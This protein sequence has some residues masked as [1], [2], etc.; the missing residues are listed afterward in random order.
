M[1]INLADND[2]RD[3]YTVADGNSQTVFT[4]SFEIFDDEDLNV[5]IDG[6]LQTLTTNYKISDS[7][8][9]A[10]AGHTSGTTGHVHMTSAV[11]ASGADKIIVLTRDI[12]HKRTTDFPASG[13][14]QIGS[15]NTELDKLIAIAADLNDEIGRSLRLTD[16]DTSVSLVLPDVDSRKGTVLAFDSTTGAVVA[17][18]QTG[19]VNTLASIATD[20]ATLA[21]IEDGTDATD[22]IQDVAAIAS[23]VTTVA[24]IDSNV[25]TVAGIQANVTTVAGIDT[26]VTAVA[27]IDTDVSDV[28]A[29]AGNVTTVAGIDTEVTTVSGDSADIQTLANLS[30]EIGNLGVSSITT[31][32]SALA[33]TAVINDMDALADLTTEID[34]L[35]DITSDITDVAAVDSDVTT[36]AGEISPTNNISTVAGKATE[37]GRLGTTAAVADM[38]ALGASAVVADMDTLA[39]ISAD[40]T[41]LAHL[42]DGTDATNAISD[43]AAISADITAVAAIEQDIQDVQDE[44][45]NIQTLANDLNE[46][47]SEIDTVAASIA[48]VDLVGGSITN[49]NTVATNLTS[50]NN[51]GERYRVSAT[52]PSTS[53][54][55]G[56]LWFDTTNDVMKVYGSGGF[57][58]AGSSVNGTSNRVD[59]VVGTASGDYDGT[60][61]TVFEATYDAGYVDVYLNGIKLQPADFTA[62]NGTDIT[63]ATAAQTSDTVSI[64]GYGTFNLANFSINDAN[65]VSTSGITNGQVLAYNSTTTNFEAA[66]ITEAT[67]NE[68]ENVVED[69]TPQLGGNL[70]VNSN[71]IVS[72]SNGDIELEPNGTGVV[73]VDGT[74]KLDN[75]GTDWTFEIDTNKLV[76]KYGGTAKM[77]LDTSGNLKVTGDVTAFG[78]I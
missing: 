53:L 69:T 7:A 5:Y 14:F 38:A 47:T 43:L 4:M 48:N 31:A 40:I 77:E 44:I 30:T 19:N 57:A 16:Y 42:E 76:I 72:T 58:N 6:T 67:G 39:D 41:T 52:A 46:V 28:A 10:D 32:M 59:Y 3:S 62:T 13:A 65:D 56:D 24:N 68:L 63:L 70:D 75:G 50:V 11:V 1:T 27:A 34:A 12:E 26:D 17:G 36:V 22:A 37:I 74:L 54:D 29:I 60:S 35:G 23:N 78:T 73:L 9:D 61:T 2:P 71:K 20:I 66:S 51:F 25:T 55:V 18:P 8:S 45:A 64:V 49:V 21:D 15:L 33:V